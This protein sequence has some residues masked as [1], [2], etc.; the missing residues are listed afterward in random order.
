M[1]LFIF[2]L[3]YSVFVL[4]GGGLLYTSSHFE[5]V[6][7]IVG[8][9]YVVAVPPLDEF[10]KV[11]CKE[12]CRYFAVT[13][14]HHMGG[15]DWRIC[16]E[17]MMP[18]CHGIKK[19]K[20]KLQAIINS[21]RDIA[22]YELEYKDGLT[23]FAELFGDTLLVQSIGKG[24][25]TK[26]DLF[27]H[28]FNKSNHYGIL[29]SD[30]GAYA[31]VPEWTSSIPYSYE[32]SSELEKSQRIKTL[33][34][35]G[36]LVAPVH[37]VPGQSGS[38]LVAPIRATA[39]LNTYEIIGHSLSYH[40]YANQ[41]TFLNKDLIVNTIKK[42]Y[43]GKTGP[44]GSLFGDHAKW[45]FNKSFGTTYRSLD[46]AEIS[47]IAVSGLDHADFTVKDQLAGNIRDGDSGDKKQG[48][49]GDKKQ[50]DGGDKKQGDGGDKKQGDGGDKKQGDG[51]DKK[52]GDG[53]DKKQGDGGECSNSGVE[54]LDEDELKKCITGL[55]DTSILPGILFRGEVIQGFNLTHKGLDIPIY[56][57]WE[58]LLLADKLIE[59]G[60]LTPSKGGP[61][62]AE[63][64]QRLSKGKVS[65]KTKTKCMVTKG[66]VN[67]ASLHISAEGIT[68]Y[69]GKS[70]GKLY[71]LLLDGNGVEI[72]AD[73]KVFDPLK[74][75]KKDEG[76]FFLDITGLFYMDLTNTYMDRDSET[77]IDSIIKAYKKGPSIRM[78]QIDHD[79]RKLGYL[80]DIHFE[81]CVAD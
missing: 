1:K 3:T 18:L 43:M 32:A 54:S 37:I 20:G 79:S 28:M 51:G 5:G 40:R 56:A 27:S 45:K 60:K 6:G 59:N 64:M 38:P 72:G 73:Q 31:I 39:E 46:K 58:S 69:Y 71:P 7:N 42:L 21:S 22:V 68:V 48:D 66:K 13:T 67:C 77:T 47:E 53:G 57:D 81:S 75:K 63:T 17:D 80:S 30:E 26:N 33:A 15:R 50:G 2:L 41:S 76:I 35:S 34:V 55:S 65:C 70:P 10:P 61:S 52:Q 4:S 62:V 36:N 29:A 23:A 49:G 19:L 25:R 14:A 24:E 44:S 11:T 74:V 8:T 12:Q 9:G 78:S 16:E